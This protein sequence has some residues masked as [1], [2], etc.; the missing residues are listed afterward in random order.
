[1]GKHIPTSWPDQECINKLVRK[2]SG[3]FIYASTIAKFVADPHA[4]PPKQLNIIFGL[5][6]PTNASPFSELDALYLHLLSAH[7]FPNILL[8]IL[9]LSLTHPDLNNTKSIGWFLELS[10][11]EVELALAP[12]SSVIA[13]RYSVIFPYH[14]S[15][16]EFLQDQSRSRRF[17]VDIEA[18]KIKA[19]GL[20]VKH[21]NASGSKWI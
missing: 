4:F 21:L 13:L 16:F 6:P 5:D 15:F 19:L 3:Q 12:L 8:D 1:M 10:Q 9:G 20:A 14:A 7:R 11:G 18:E 17:Y 2:S